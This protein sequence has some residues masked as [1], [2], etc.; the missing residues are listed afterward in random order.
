MCK[1]QKYIKDRL[2]AMLSPSQAYPYKM[3]LQM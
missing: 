1:V 2:P 3:I